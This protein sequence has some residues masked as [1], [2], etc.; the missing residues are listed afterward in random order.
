[1]NGGG[2]VKT[3]NCRFMFVGVLAVLFML[4]VVMNGIGVASALAQEETAR[5]KRADDVYELGKTVVT[6][7][8]QEEN[9]Q[10]IPL[11]ITAFEEYAI[12]DRKIETIGEIADFVPNLMLFDDSIS[13][14]YTPSIRGI[15]SPNQSLSSSVGLYVDGVPILSG[16]GFDADIID[17]ERI[18][19]LRGPQGT[20]YGKNTESGAINIITHKPDNMLRGKA[21]LQAGEDEKRQFSLNLSGPIQKDKLFMGI[22]GQYYQKDGFL[23]NTLT[24][25]TVDDREN[26]FFRGNLRWAP[27]DDVD[28]S[29]IASYK[30]YDE[31]T[32]CL[33]WSKEG[34]AK[35]G[36]PEPQDRLVSSNIN[37]ENKSDYDSQAL[38][39]AYEISDSLTLTSISTRRKSNNRVKLDRDFSSAILAHVFTDNTYNKMSQELRLNWSSDRLKSLFALY[40]DK[41]DDTLNYELISDIPSMAGIFNQDLKGEAY[42]AFAHV[43]YALTRK[44]SLTGGLRYERQTRDYEDKILSITADD[45]WDEVSPKVAVDYQLTP[46]IMIYSSVTKGYRTG[47]FNSFTSDPAFLSYDEETL[48]SYEVGAKSSFFN[49]RLIINSCAY[50]MDIND[51]QVYEAITPQVSYMTNAAKATGRGVE[52]E[53]TARVYDGIDVMAGYGYSDVEFDSFSDV[54]GN[55]E[56]N[57]SPYAP[58]YSFNLGVQYRHALGLY[59]RA[60]Y[61]GYGK[62]YF[63][64]ANTYSKGAYEIVNTKIGYEATSFDIYLYAKNLF[65]ET[66]DSIGYYGGVYTIY[67]PP[68]EIGAQVVY[69]F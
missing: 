63:D 11:S 3:W 40:Y 32:N 2:V 27:T 23:E 1:M 49:N 66:Y 21:S 56:G 6:A 18:E 20:L 17:I 65:D 42:A 50:Y 59:A 53:I 52:V 46:G 68:R 35:L 7:Q 5:K 44:L 58:E 4:T 14:A 48:W 51:M 16:T 33:N 38:K 19:V 24:G 54:Q 43:T 60:D 30:K 31:G 36:L 69:R 15:A 9:I 39:I 25:D 10:D 29:L 8:K 57:K 45:E 47:G 26:R 64:R 37:G 34:A 22:A 55:Y 41:D 67:S 12:E 61:I 28:I 62:M 13:G